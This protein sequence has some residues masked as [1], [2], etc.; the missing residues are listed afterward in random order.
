MYS[1]AFCLFRSC[2]LF[3]HETSP[4][5]NVMHQRFSVPLRFNN[6]GH[7][8]SKDKE[9]DLEWRVSILTRPPKQNILETWILSPAIAKASMVRKHNINLTVYVNFVLK[10]SNKTITHWN[11]RKGKEGTYYS[12]KRSLFYFWHINNLI[13]KNFSYENLSW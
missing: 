12:A 1:F 13:R 7:L 8:F 11:D 4:L 6:S 5:D 10:I 9:S 2:N 3:I